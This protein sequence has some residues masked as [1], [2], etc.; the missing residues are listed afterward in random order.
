MKRWLSIS[1]L[2]P[3]GLEGGIS[4]FLM[5]QGSTG[6]EEIDEGQEKKRLKAYFLKDGKE[7]GALQALNRY[8][9]SLRTIVPEASSIQIETV[10]LPEQDWGENWK[11]FFRPIRVGSKFVVKPPWSKIRLQK[12]RIPIVI[13]PGMAF[14]TG[15][16]ATT[17]LCIQELEARLRRRGL[18]VLDVG[19]GSGILSIAAAKLGAGEAWG[20]DID[21]V[22][23]GAARENVE[24]NNVSHITRM[25]KTSIGHILKKFDIVV[26][27]IDLKS[28]QR[29]RMPLLRHLKA[30]GFLILSGILEAERDRLCQNYLKTGLFQW[31]KVTQEEGWACLT[32]K[33]K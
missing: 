30:Q 26:A 16:H 11:N 18:S 9:N 12:G 17:K 32:L 23:I 21:G 13:T 22:A 31:V 33:R 27:N 7:K 29:M 2:V 28:L 25:R 5:E 15:T 20:L 10:T 1:L 8:L 24:Q 6:I 14:G 19:T 3:T 4:N